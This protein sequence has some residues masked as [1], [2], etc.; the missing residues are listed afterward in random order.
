M[1]IDKYSSFLC[2]YLNS[3]LNDLKF[4]YFK[5]IWN[6]SDY[7]ISVNGDIVSPIGIN[8]TTGVIFKKDDNDI[9]TFTLPDFYSLYLSKKL[10]IADSTISFILIHKKI[11]D[12]FH[13]F[14]FSLFK[15][16]NIKYHIYIKEK[17]DELKIYHFLKSSSGFRIVFDEQFNIVDISYNLKIFDKFKKNNIY[18]K[19]IIFTF[20]THFLNNDFSKFNLSDDEVALLEIEDFKRYL[21]LNNI[22]NY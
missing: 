15:K 11:H 12:T 17:N 19:Y 13:D 1:S 10:S 21:E 6:F 20:Y 2:S 14:N 22:I 18:E 16:N 3:I 7:D 4:D 9:F 5:S 8:Y